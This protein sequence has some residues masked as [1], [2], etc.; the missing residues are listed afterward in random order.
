M[1]KIKKGGRGREKEIKK[2]AEKRVKNSKKQEETK[3]WRKNSVEEICNEERKGRKEEEGKVYL[4]N[5]REKKRQKE[6]QKLIH[7][8][9]YLFGF[10][11]FT[12]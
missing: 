11:F 7:S 2:D 12:S 3:R 1:K 10:S 6:S 9:I 4:R 8:F 5:E